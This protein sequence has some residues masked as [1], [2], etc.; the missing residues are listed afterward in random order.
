MQITEKTAQGLKREYNVV[1][2]ASIIEERMNARLVE[3]GQQVS[4]PGFRP[5]KAPMNL[6]KKRFGQSVM[7]EVLDKAINDTAQSVITEK[8][9]KPAMQPKIELVNFAEGK[10]LEFD[11][12]VEVLPDIATPDF[13]KIELEKWVAP[14][15]DEVLNKALEALTQANKT[16]KAITENRKAKNGDVLVIDFVGKLNDV[17][18]DGG[19][20]FDTK[21]ELGSGQ[22]I[23]GF[24]D[25]LVGATAGDKVVVNVKFPADYGAAELAG[26]DAVFNVTVKE[27]HEIEV[28]ALNDDFAK[29]LGEESL[30]TLKSK[31]REV[32]QSN[33]D[34]IAR[35]R[36]KRTLLDKLSEI[37]TFPVPEGM[38]DAEFDAIWKQIEQA[39]S[40]NQLDA[41]DAKK[42]DDDLRKEYRAIAERRVRLGLLL[43]DVGT[44][45]NIAVTPEELGRAVM[46]QASRFRGQEQAVV[47][48]YKNTPEALESLRAPVFEDK[49]VDFILELAKVSTKEVSIEELEKDPE[50]PMGLI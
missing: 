10:D 35:L 17:A 29:K 16:T 21:L 42:S 31:S 11:V 15:T 48:Y 7:G 37:E 3:V 24:E 30:D 50:T 33:H 22:F 9:L 19:T 25:Q 44:K 40:A 8:S 27:I 46:E 43:S 13:K 14:V 38:V 18:F 36:L 32:L 12:K 41:D 20:G 49:V 2:A 28:A 34:R 39:K 5:G 6:L 4:L 45:N 23:P 47:N 1:I 26:Q